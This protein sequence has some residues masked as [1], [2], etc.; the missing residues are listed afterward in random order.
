MPFSMGF[1]VSLTCPAV[2]S[3]ARHWR[4]CPALRG[5]RSFRLRWL[6]L[7]LRLLHPRM[8]LYRLM[9]GL[10]SLALALMRNR[11]GRLLVGTVSG[12]GLLRGG[13]FGTQSIFLESESSSDPQKQRH[14]KD[15][16]WKKNARPP[17]GIPATA[18]D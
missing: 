12:R 17:H 3:D 18:Q 5:L 4:M 6:L 16:K 14:N 10:R 11:R 9:A 8:R 1:G 7:R 13:P 2:R 15:K